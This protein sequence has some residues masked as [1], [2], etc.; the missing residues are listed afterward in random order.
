MAQYDS[1]RDSAYSTAGDADLLTARYEQIVAETT[2]DERIAFI[3]RT[4]AHLAG[5][6]VVFI[7]V[8]SLLM[9]VLDVPALFGPLLTGYGWLIVL[10][11]FLLVS[12]LANHWAQSATSPGIQYMG[13]GLYILLESVI[14]LPLIYIATTHYGD[15]NVLPIAAVTT[16]LL[17]GVMTG[18]VFTSQR[19]FSFMGPLLAVA[20]V[21]ALIFIVGA[22][23]MG[24]IAL[25][26]IFTVFMILLMCGWILYHTSAVLHHYKTNQHVAASL[27]LF[28]SLATLFWYVL[29]L[30]MILADRR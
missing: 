17:F 10:G 7:G 28:A 25:G 14:F 19:D 11:V 29:R 8:L 24:G 6:V 21:A 3:R 26:L 18:Y 5:A 12:H 4:Y 1:R 9:T 15:Q 27:A 13:L 16:L 30:A 22:I 20:S 2:V 23:L